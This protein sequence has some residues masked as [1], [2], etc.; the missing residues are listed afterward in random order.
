[1]YNGFF[2]KKT[3]SPLYFMLY[4]TLFNNPSYT[5]FPREEIDGIPLNFRRKI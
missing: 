5:N 4:F 3:Y 1:M 2:T